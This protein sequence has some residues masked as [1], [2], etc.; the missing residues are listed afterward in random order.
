[1]NLNI[2]NIIK[3]E[4][5]KKMVNE[6]YKIDVNI[7]KIAGYYEIK[8]AYT[9]EN[10]NDNNSLRPNINLSSRYTDILYF[11][12]KILKQYNI[13]HSIIKR[14][15]TQNNDNLFYTLRISS[16]KNVYKFF[17][18]FD[19]YIDICRDEYTQVKNLVYKKMEK[20]RK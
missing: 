17:L 13:N 9:I 16:Y 14:I 15:S 19:S 7:I 10:R 11:I 1:M 3:I 8:G 2:I 20:K 18:I 5:N 12:S 6:Y 4:I